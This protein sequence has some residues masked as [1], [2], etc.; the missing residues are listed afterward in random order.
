MIRED[1]VERLELKRDGTYAW[2]PPPA[3]APGTGEWVINKTE[4]GSDHFWFREAMRIL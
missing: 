4:D 1:Y 3:W 2:N